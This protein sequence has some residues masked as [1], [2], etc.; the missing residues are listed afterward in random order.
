VV[1]TTDVDE[2]RHVFRSIYAESSL[3]PDPTRPFAWGLD[4]ISC[5]PVQ[6]TLGLSNGAARVVAP[7]AANRPY[8]L[9][10]S[11]GGK[12]DAELAAQHH[13]IVRGRSGA[14]LSPNL[15]LKLQVEAGFQGRN[16]TIERA[17][18]EAHL[19]ALTGHTP[20]APIVF[21]PAMDF[22][23]HP[24]ATLY[25]IVQVFGR[26]VEQPNASPLLVAA[27]RDAL[28]TGL[29]TCVKHSASHLLDPKPSR[30]GP[31]YVKRAE[32]YI[33]AHA[34]EPI[35]L[36]QIAAAVGASERSLRAAFTARHGVAPM[37][38]LRRRRFEIAR[39][40]LAEATPGTTVLSV[41][42]ALGLGDPGRFSVE[43][44]KRF[45]QS[46]S[47]TLAGGRASVGMIALRRA[48]P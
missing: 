5:G 14:V 8:I 9:M 4:R 11:G 2:A 47:E 41:I 30:V 17:A 6:V 35:T 1:R 10:L 7:A 32:E 31:G 15:P 18:L 20:S 46:P 24:G 19:T 12:S 23:T 25:G 21:D 44:R 28:M 43:F 29:L 13:A 48:G 40:R 36:A 33:E 3:E 38:F 37:E 22:E 42:K 39:R 27:L 26:E 16:I 34:A 45:G